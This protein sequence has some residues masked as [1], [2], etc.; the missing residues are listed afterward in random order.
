MERRLTEE[1]SGVH[2]TGRKNWNRTRVIEMEARFFKAMI[3]NV[4]KINEA[5]YENSRRKTLNSSSIIPDRIF[6]KTTK[7]HGTPEI[8]KIWKISKRF[9]KRRA[10]LRRNFDF[11]FE[12]IW[13]SISI[14]ISKILGSQFRFRFRILKF[15]FRLSSGSTPFSS[16]QK[17]DTWLEERKRFCALALLVAYE[18]SVKFYS[19]FIFVRL[20]DFFVLIA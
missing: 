7:N 4:H 14:S 1:T 17:R 5:G 12:K 2:T 13:R 19:R 20:F 10:E 11:D 15:Q 9:W 16:Y 18:T 3:W 8:E 6:Q